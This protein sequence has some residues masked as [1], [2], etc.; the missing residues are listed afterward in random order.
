MPWAIELDNGDH[1]WFVQGTYGSVDGPRANYRCESGHE[2]LGDL[3]DSEPQ[4]RA[5]VDGDIGWTFVR[6]AWV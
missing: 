6:R 3:D 4:L 1:C 5:F 2:V